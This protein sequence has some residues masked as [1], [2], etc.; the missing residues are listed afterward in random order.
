M[1]EESERKIERERDSV[2]RKK[3]SWVSYFFGCCLYNHGKNDHVYDIH[4]FLNQKAEF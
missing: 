2:N 3:T 1:S 4:E